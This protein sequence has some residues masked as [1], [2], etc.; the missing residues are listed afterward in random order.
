MPAYESSASVRATPE[1]V[2]RILSDVAAWPEWL[3]TVSRVDP[4]D[5]RALRL[6]ARFIVHQPRLRPATWTVSQLEPPRSFVWISRS[7]GL[8]MV[9]EHTITVETPGHSSV[10]LRF[11]FHGLLGALVGRLYRTLV[12]DYLAQEAAS[13]KTQAEAAQ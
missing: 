8:E 1:T 3:P 4:L 9:A 6:G 12:Q 13:L 5:Q 10:V 11:S 2:W 7:P